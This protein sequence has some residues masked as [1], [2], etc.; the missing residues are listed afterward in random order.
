MKIETMEQLE[1]LYYTKAGV[2]ALSPSQMIY[3][4]DDPVTSTTPGVYNAIYGAQAWIQLNQEANAFGVLPKIP[5]DVGGRSGWRVITARGAS[6]PTGGVA[7]NGAIPDTTK[8]TLAEV[9]TKPKTIAHPFENSEVLETLSRVDD[10][11]GDMA[12]LR[13]YFAGEHKEHM[14]AYLLQDND[15]LAGNGL[16][17][18]DRVVSSYDEINNCG[19]DAGDSDIYSLDRDGGATWSDAYVD[20]NSNS[21]RD[22]TDSVIR[23]VRDGVLENGGNPQ[24]WL[25]GIDTSSTISG[26]YDPQVR[27]APLGET[28]I[29]PSVNGIQT[30]QGLDMG[31]NVATLYGKPVIQAK[32]AP[33]AQTG[34]TLSRLYLLDTSNPEG[35][36]MPRLSIK[37]VAPTQYFENGMNKGDPFAIDAF[38]NK[39]VYRTIGELICTFFKAQ[40]KARDLS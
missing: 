37:I 38:A 25:T 40:G 22:L 7:E 35:F 39:G 5:W 13:S 21:G 30:M 17:S 31:V 1:N 18:I 14:N 4:S 9:S 36:D 23:A 28:T 24:F 33:S 27:Y 15:T 16:E 19:M 20:H 11:V 8:P 10:T 12:M 2:Q 6:T 3:K 26:L 29:Q 34:D 32:D